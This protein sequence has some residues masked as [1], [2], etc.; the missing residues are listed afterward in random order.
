MNI[1]HYNK[2]TGE[3]LGETEAKLDPLDKNPLIP[4][5]ATEDKPPNAPAKKAVIRVGNAWEL[6]DD[7]RGE[8]WFAGFG[9]PE[10]ITGIGTPKGLTK[11]EPPS[12]TVIQPSPQEQNDQIARALANEGT[13]KL[14]EVLAEANG[15][16][17][18]QLISAARSKNT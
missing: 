12:F 17:M 14:F 16:N 2:V 15:M 6:I 18:G 10:E 7:F 1:Y 9:A 5:N 8:I 13:R 11:N 3:Y 4:A